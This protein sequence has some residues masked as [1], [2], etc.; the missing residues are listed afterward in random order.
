M[1]QYA[2]GYIGNRVLKLNVGFLLAD[3]PGHSHETSF[4]VPAIRVA[5]DVD[6]AYLRGPLRLSRT[7][8]GILVQGQLHVGIEEECYRCLDATL[9]DHVIAVE[10]LYQYPRSVDAEYGIDEDAVVDL[11][12][13]IRAEAII[14]DS[15]GVL[16]RPDCKGLCPNCGTNWNHGVCTCADDEIDP[17]FAKLKELL[18]R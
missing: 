12:P 14:A 11:A 15:H 10:E 16:C 9:V 2:N 6:L 5:E 4:D 1:K 13:L 7:K 17:R 3:G 8:E 18:E